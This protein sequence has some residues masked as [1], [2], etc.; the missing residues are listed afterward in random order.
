MR[1]FAFSSSSRTKSHL[2]SEHKLESL[3]SRES[4]FLFNNLL[5]VGG[6]LHGAVGNVVPDDFRM[7]AG[8]Q[9]HGR[10]AVLQQSG[11]PGG[12]AAAV[13]TAVGPLLAWRKTSLDSLKRNFLWPALGALAVGVLMIVF[14]VRP[15][16]DIVV[17]LCADGGH[18]VRTG[19]R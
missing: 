14:G 7:G 2:R 17:L 13:L 10:A 1:S 6:V 15:W 8:Q 5:L 4:S 3:I 12:A 18:A 19:H 9:S 16:K 11:D